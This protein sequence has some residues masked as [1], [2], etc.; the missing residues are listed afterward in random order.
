M[1]SGQYVQ[2][3]APGVYT[4][5]AVRIERDAKSS[6]YIVK[7]QGNPV[8]AFG[9]DQG[10]SYLKEGLPSGTTRPLMESLQWLARGGQFEPAYPP[11]LGEGVNRRE[12]AGLLRNSLPAPDQPPPIV[13]PPP[14]DTTSAYTFKQPLPKL[15]STRDSQNPIIESLGDGALRLTYGGRS[16]TITRI[17]PI[18]GSSHN[19]SY[20]ISGEDFNTMFRRL[21]DPHDD[22]G[23]KAEFRDGTNIAQFRAYAHARG[24]GRKYDDNRA[25]DPPI[26]SC[27]S[28]GMRGDRCGPGGMLPAPGGP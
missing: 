13:K 7:W 24:E 3:G 10:F 15:I 16:A 8:A 2:L 18:G 20:A 21:L 12:V 17:G 25:K 4:S 11:A 6:G 19:D 1:A 5:G 23:A 28:A 14:L 22:A 27:G 9:P 26:K